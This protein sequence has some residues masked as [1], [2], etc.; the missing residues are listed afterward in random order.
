MNNN[1]KKICFVNDNSVELFIPKIFNDTSGNPYKW[2][3]CYNFN[4]ENNEKK[5]RLIVSDLININLVDKNKNI[6]D[7]G[8]FIGDNSL[9]WAKQ[10]NGLVYAIDPSINNEILINYLANINNIKN[11]I[12]YK[13][14]LSDKEKKLSFNG[15][16]D[17][18]SFSHIGGVNTIL[19]TSLDILFINNKINDITFI[20]LDVEGEEYNTLLGSIETIQKFK[21]IIIYEQ[22]IITDNVLDCI[23]LLD[24]LG[25]HQYIINEQTGERKDCRNFLAIPNE[26]YEFFMNNS[27]ILSYLIDVSNLDNEKKL[28]K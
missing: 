22:H 25:Y 23:N 19:A 17:F 20:H 9:P 6:I 1:L 2:F 8:A 3:N 11:L 5:T 18:N 4:I 26:K 7:S 14:V 27:K 21:P 28:L 24:S 13:N 15:D 12:Y 16:L 10:I